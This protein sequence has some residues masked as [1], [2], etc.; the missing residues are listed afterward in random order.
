MDYLFKAADG[1][2]VTQE[3]LREALIKAGAD[4]ADILYV[5][6]D[7][8][9]GV[10]NAALGR[11][12]I[13]AGLLEGIESLG[14]GTIVFPTV[15]F[16]FPNGKD[17]DVNRSKTKMGALNEY[18]R[19]IPEAVRSLDP[20][21]SVAVIG[22]KKYLATGIGHASIGRDSTFDM[23]AREENVKFLFLGV[24]PGL[25]FTYTHYVEWAS[26]TPYRYDRPFT[27]RIKDAGGNTYEATYD[28][29]VRYQGVTPHGNDLPE[30]ME[31][32]GAMKTEAVGDDFIYVIDKDPAQ[33]ILTERL[34]AEPE[35]MVTIEKPFRK[36]DTFTLD[37]E[38]VA[39]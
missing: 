12:G 9:F 34:A 37:K 33:E 36:D 10:P 13:M 27:G 31:K 18:A 17:Y 14:V 5:H 6:S 16:S 38:M 8:T 15:T 28:L 2:L 26:K 35:Y 7:M 29:F 1:S 11:K 4:K 32:A 22:D 3:S 19:R 30:R 39:L 21:M 20:L 25:C 23:I 24:H